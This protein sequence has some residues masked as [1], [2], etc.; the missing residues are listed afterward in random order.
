MFR[1]LLEYFHKIKIILWQYLLLLFIGLRSRARHQEALKAHPFRM[2]MKLWFWSEYFSEFKHDTFDR[3]LDILFQMTIAL[4]AK[5]DRDRD[6]LIGL[7]KS[8]FAWVS[9]SDNLRLVKARSGTAIN[10][11]MI[12]YKSTRS[13]WILRNSNGS[14]PRI[15]SL[16]R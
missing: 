3:D 6:E 8:R 9:V 2:D 14:R 12:L 13:E 15:R 4:C 16:S 11:L 1:I 5:N 7:M 10:L